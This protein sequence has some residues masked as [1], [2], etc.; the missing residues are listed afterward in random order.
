MDGTLRNLE[1]RAK[2]DVD[3]LRALAA[4]RE[5]AGDARGA[6]RARAEVARLTDA[7]DDWRAVEP[8]RSAPRTPTVRLNERCSR[9]VNVDHHGFFS[10]P[11]RG[12]LAFLDRDGGELWSADVSGR[13][14]RRSD[15]LARC[16]GDVLAASEV[17]LRLFGAEGLVAEA[18][19][20]LD[21]TR[22]GASRSLKVS[23]DRAELTTLCEEP[24]GRGL[25]T[26]IDVGARFGEV[27]LQHPLAAER[28]S[29][30]EDEAVAGW[31]VRP[32]IAHTPARAIV[33]ACPFSTG[34]VA[35]SVE[36]EW[37]LTADA[38]G[39][40]L[41]DA[42]R[43]RFIE[44]DLRTGALRWSIEHGLEGKLQVELGPDHVAV[45]HRGLRVLDRASGAALWD[46][47]CDE[48]LTLAVVG[49]DLAVLHADARDARR[50]G[51][52]LSVRDVH[53]GVERWRTALVA[54]LA[55]EPTVGARFDGRLFCAG[56]A[57]VAHILVVW[58]DGSAWSG[59]AWVG[60]DEAPGRRT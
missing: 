32:R 33:E 21:V 19:L 41:R 18:P 28:R 51:F 31:H 10:T 56:G 24:R 25:R 42:G 36:H 13:E 59:A 17:G 60:E 8:R 29:H 43:K 45:A 26:T 35:W 34:V 37:N 44:R 49:P 9:V 6:W 5:R 38:R 53:T 48:V 52:S 23:G 54:G 27:L 47:E 4:A 39:V 30:L 15:T 40:L 55:R 11:R 1:L 50:D 14:G 7:L 16:G 20:D 12:Q 46:A 2:D 57:L 58:P 22:S 3:A